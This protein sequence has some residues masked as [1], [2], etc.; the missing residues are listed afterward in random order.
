VQ[1]AD[2]KEAYTRSGELRISANGVLETY[3][4]Y[5]VLGDGGPITLP[6]PTSSRS[7]SMARFPSGPW[8]GAL[9]PGRGRSHQTGQSTADQLPKALMV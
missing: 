8:S 4:G 9:D 2:G 5:A 1:G 6:P 3:G 7:V